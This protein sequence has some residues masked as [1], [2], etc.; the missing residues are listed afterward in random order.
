MPPERGTTRYFARKSSRRRVERRRQGQGSQN[1]G[2]E[3]P[4][5]QTTTL[6]PPATEDEDERTKRESD[7]KVSAEFV[8]RFTEEAHYGRVPPDPSVLPESFVCIH[9]E[10]L[11]RREENDNPWVC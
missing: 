10:K 8:Q 4:D 6:S 2:P 11:V 9:C 1:T 5:T 3:R 7:V